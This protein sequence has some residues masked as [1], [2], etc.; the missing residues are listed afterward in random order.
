MKKF[1]LGA[2]LAAA[3]VASQPASA[4]IRVGAILS[5]TGAVAT[6]GIPMRKALEVLPKTLGGEPL[7][8]IIL[9]DASDPNAAT[10]A[11]RKL[12]TEERVDALLGP[13]L[14]PATLAASQV[15]AEL[16]T[17]L[18]SLGGGGA[19]VLPMDA[20]RRWIFKMPPAENFQLGVMFKDMKARGMKRLAVIGVTNAYGQ[21]FIDE[22]QKLAPPEGI[23][24]VS[25]ERFSNSDTSFVSQAVKLTAAKPDA[26]LIAAAGT[27]AVMPQLALFDRGYKGQ[28]YQTQPVATDDFLRVGGSRVNGTRIMISPVFVAEQLPDSNVTKAESMR[29]IKAW[30]AVY[31]NER[32]LLA[33]GMV[34]DAHLLLD[35]AAKKALAVAKPGTPEFRKALR[36]ALEQTKEK[37]LT[38]GVYTMTPQDHSGAD[39]RSQVLVEIKDG[40]WTYVE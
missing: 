22:T 1:L 25:V 15:A 24:V 36:D 34:W 14:T 17:P 6:L 18:I 16:G 23:E 40:K 9:D 8:F 2:V 33:S 7:K 38:Q 30:N 12:T 37:V 39:E 4:E 35:D 10:M 20:T 32:H 19:I 26:V 28:I 29:F 11:A 27:P 3:A 31:P 21:I 5:Q 13:V